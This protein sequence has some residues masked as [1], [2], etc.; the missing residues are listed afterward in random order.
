MIRQIR[1]VI[2]LYADRA[3]AAYGG[4]IEE[5]LLFGSVARG[6]DHQDSDIDILVITQ[7]DNREV[8]SKL[9][10]LAFDLLLETEEYISVKVIPRALVEER[11]HHLFFRN[12]YA[13]AIAV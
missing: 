13:D 8:R 9:I 3:R 5:I 6:D 12:V 10:D 4:A 1:P 2:K 7:A 11:R